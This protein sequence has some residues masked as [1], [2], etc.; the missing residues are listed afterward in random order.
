MKDDNIDTRPYELNV[1][2]AVFDRDLARRLVGGSTPATS[3]HFGNEDTLA[4]W[5]AFRKLHFS[6]PDA[7]AGKRAH[8]TAIAAGGLSYHVCSKERNPNRSVSIRVPDSALSEQ[9]EG[10]VHF[11]IC[12]D[13]CDGGRTFLE[14]G[15]Q[16][17][18]K[19]SSLVVTHGL[20]S[21]RTRFLEMCGIFHSIYTTSS[22]G[23]VPSDMVV[24]ASARGCNFKQVMI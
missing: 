14:I 6:A 21:D 2:R 4:V 11:V 20:F 7:G 13:I 16:F 3:E 19:G 10:D 12:D 24:E 17:A 5:R 22:V 9:R 15:R 18:P 23:M 8:D 1:L